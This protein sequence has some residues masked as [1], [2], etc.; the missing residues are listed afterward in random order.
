MSN[1]SSDYVDF[2]DE[3][4]ST[5]LPALL[6]DPIGVLQRQYRWILATVV[7]PSII[8]AGATA[9]ISLRYE[10]EATII[11]TSKSIPDEFVPTTIVASIVE[12]FDAISSEVFSRD[13]LSEIIQETDVYANERKPLTRSKLVDRLRKDL[14]VEPI[15]GSSRSQGGA[16][17]ISFR[18]SMRGKDPQVL[19][20]VVNT[21]IA[22][23]INENVKYRSRQARLTT[24]FMQ[25]EYERADT[26]LRDHQRQ[27]GEF[28]EKNRGALPEERTTAISRL[29][30]LE[31]QR[32]SAIIRLSDF[33]TR[34]EHL[35]ARPKI[36]DTGK[37]LESLRT[38]LRKARTLYTDDHPRVRSLER[39]VEAT[40]S[41]RSTGE[42]ADD[43]RQRD[44]R[45]QIQKGAASEQLRLSQI[46]QEVAR[47]EMLLAQTPQIA[48][49]YAALVRLEQILQ[50][51]YVE[52]L[53]KLKSAELALSL[54][55]AQQG[56]QLKRID[57][58]VV[59]TAP[60]IKRWQIAGAGFVA[61]IGLATL[62]AIAREL[63]NPVIID[64]QHLEDTLSVPLL[65]SIGKIA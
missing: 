40:D 51:N 63:L 15:A 34:L 53:R 12:Q 10:A 44:E 7:L 14:V 60:I 9:T 47:L 26:A 54:E 64:E 31:D 59:P 3:D 6:R 33:Q 5:G 57:A 45:S 29:D 16:S 11:L 32:R 42:T 61:A 43:I 41:V 56:S 62:V 35:E 2:R 30:R 1:E 48:E 55:S 23:L 13:H 36:I 19:A 58:A 17:S 22:H 39:Q 28:R 27:L 21:T 20:N 24:E 50:E 46:D 4:E 49:E 37:N 52:Y 25:R 8:V 65:G 18:L 38:Q